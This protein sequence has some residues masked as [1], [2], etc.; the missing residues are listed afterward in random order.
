M[1]AGG[2]AARHVAR[3]HGGTAC[4]PE[5]RRHGMS[6][7]AVLQQGA[8]PQQARGRG[9]DMSASFDMSETGKT[10]FDGQLAF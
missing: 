7:G 5:S 8:L 3:S 10:K 1:S 9:L 6:H 2:T 4:R